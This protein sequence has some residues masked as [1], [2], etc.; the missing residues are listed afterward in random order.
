LFIA[1]TQLNKRKM[2]DLKIIQT[3]KALK[4]IVL[5]AWDKAQK[6]GWFTGQIP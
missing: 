3:E 4:T 5:I 1:E 2:S 6:L